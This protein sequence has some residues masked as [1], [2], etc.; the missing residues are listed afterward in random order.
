MFSSLQIFVCLKL[1]ISNFVHRSRF[2]KTNG[3]LTLTFGNLLASRAG[4]GAE[5]TNCYFHYWCYGGLG[6]GMSTPVHTC[7]HGEPAGLSV[8]SFCSLLVGCAG[9]VI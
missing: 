3:G 7:T 4:K 9:R 6:F 8:S 5:T 2:Y 1:K